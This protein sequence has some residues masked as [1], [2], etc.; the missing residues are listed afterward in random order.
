MVKLKLSNININNIKKIARKIL[1]PVIAGFTVQYAAATTSP[2][3]L[4]SM[5]K[6]QINNRSEAIE[7]NF[8]GN[9]S[10]N[11]IFD[12]VAKSNIFETTNSD[13]SHDQINE[14]NTYL[15]STAANL[16]GLNELFDAK[17]KATFFYYN[18][19]NINKIEETYKKYGT[20]IDNK[21]KEIVATYKYQENISELFKILGAILFRADDIYTPNG[22]IKFT[23][24]DKRNLANECKDALAHLENNILNYVRFFYAIKAS[25]NGKDDT[26]ANAEGEKTAYELKQKLAELKTISTQHGILSQAD[27]NSLDNI[28]NGTTSI[29]PHNMYGDVKT[30]EAIVEIYCTINRVMEFIAHL[31]NVKCDTNQIKAGNV[32]ANGNTSNFKITPQVEMGAIVSNKYNGA[33]FSLCFVLPQNGNWDFVT[34]F[35][36]NLF[37]NGTTQALGKFEA[38]YTTNNNKNRFGAGLKLGGQYDQ[39]NGWSVPIAIVGNYTCILNKSAIQGKISTGYNPNLNEF[40]VGSGVSYIIKS[41]NCVFIFTVSYQFVRSLTLKNNNMITNSV[42]PTNNPGT[43]TTNPTNPGSTTSN[44]TNPDPKDPENEVT[45]P[46]PTQPDRPYGSEEGMPLQG[47]VTNE[48]EIHPDKDIDLGKY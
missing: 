43:T 48:G 20:G 37:N 24:V 3:V 25:N 30:R 13:K 36:T 38:D 6:N 1:I 31:E 18:N 10:I 8:N 2:T 15:L 44:P 28:K 40:S 45:T 46:A 41:E 27:L 11:G 5:Q 26:T 14:I 42:T 47:E 17:S 34:G 39:K 22:N 21:T 29:L 4:T 12:K 35:E 33:N 9:N 23:T 19:L 32:K 16:M 7:K